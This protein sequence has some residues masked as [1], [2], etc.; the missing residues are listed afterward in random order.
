[1]SEA[2]SQLT[3]QQL[4]NWALGQKPWSTWSQR[5]GSPVSLR[6]A[7]A[8]PSEGPSLQEVALALLDHWQR[9]CGDEVQRWGALA[10]P[11]QLHLLAGCARGQT[12]LVSLWQTQRAPAVLWQLVVVGTKGVVS[13]QGVPTELQ[14]SWNPP[15]N[16]DDTSLAQGLQLALQSNEA[17]VRQADS[18]WQTIPEQTSSE[19]LLPQQ[20]PNWKKLQGVP[21]PW[22]VLLVAGKFTHQENYAESFAQDPRCR[23]VGLSDAG[24]LTQRRRELNRQ[25][26]KRLQIPYWE[27]YASALARPEVHIVSVCGEPDRRAALEVQAAQA[28]KAVYLDK[29]L[30]TTRQEAQAVAQAM[31]QAQ[32]PNQMFSLVWVPQVQQARALLQ[33]TGRFDQLHYELFFAKGH[34]GTATLDHPRREDPE[35]RLLEAPLT[36]REWTNIAVYCLTALHHMLGPCV[37]RIYAITGNYFFSENQAA[38][39]EDFA[40]ALL[41]LEGGGVMTVRVGRTGWRSHP[42]SGIHRLVLAGSAEAKLLDVHEPHWAFWAQEPWPGAKR[43][44]GDPMGFWSSSLEEMHTPPKQDWILPPWGKD[45][46]QRFVD[47][48]DQG[49][50]PDI[51]A[52]EA[53]R[54]QHW[55]LAG[56]ESAAKSGWVKV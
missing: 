56:Y 4:W 22:G 40:A 51:T 27:D 54:V 14:G 46:I 10:P 28:G 6:V 52:L 47:H 19:L 31:A 53:A 48:L 37:K 9:V 20:E 38:D 55:L 44:P 36:K 13:L 42:H 29:P 25:W 41:E 35:P 33:Q 21:K 50:R 12:A 7:L 24:E 32:V 8:L 18:S 11:G 1:M 43:H 23:L 45:D 16:A 2:Q 49:T 5:S 26:A 15:K 39:M 17:V 30:C 34:P 3:W